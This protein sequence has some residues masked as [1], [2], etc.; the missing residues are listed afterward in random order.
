[1]LITEVFCSAYINPRIE[2][3]SLN[4][5]DYIIAIL[6]DAFLTK[7]SVIITVYLC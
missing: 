4:G 5:D 2:V 1:M 7:L 6:R 3:H